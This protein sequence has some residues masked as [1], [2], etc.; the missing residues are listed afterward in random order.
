MGMTVVLESLPVERSILI[1]V[2]AAHVMVKE[3]VEWCSIQEHHTCDH[4]VCPSTIEF[5]VFIL[6]LSVRVALIDAS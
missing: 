6:T 3:R 1:S 4:S 2:P 5:S